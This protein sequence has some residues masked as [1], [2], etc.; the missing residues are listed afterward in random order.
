[1]RPGEKNGDDHVSTPH[2]DY[3]YNVVFVRFRRQLFRLVTSLGAQRRH[4]RQGEVGHDSVSAEAMEYAISKMATTMSPLLE[5]AAKYSAFFSFLEA[6]NSDVL[7]SQRSH[8]RQG[9]V[10][11]DSVSAQAMEEEIWD[12]AVAGL[13]LAC[14]YGLTMI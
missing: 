5:T 11:S 13:S 9:E 12:W 8:G 3:S 4:G 10:G 6:V 7:V 1:V 14:W 2:K